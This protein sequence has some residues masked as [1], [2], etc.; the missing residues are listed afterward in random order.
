MT[1]RQNIVKILVIP[2][3]DPTL[4]LPARTPDFIL[5]VGYCETEGFVQRWDLLELELSASVITQSCHHCK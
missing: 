5:S 2:V 4:E 1:G 3:P